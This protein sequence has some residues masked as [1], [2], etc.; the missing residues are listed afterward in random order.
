MISTTAH[1]GLISLAWTLTAHSVPI[2]LLIFSLQHCDNWV[3]LAL[4]LVDW[5][6]IG[7]GLVMSICVG[8]SIGCHEALQLGLDWTGLHI[9]HIAYFS[10]VL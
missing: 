1:W 8:R 2:F 6:W 4:N 3:I 10:Y 9:G 7:L 5:T